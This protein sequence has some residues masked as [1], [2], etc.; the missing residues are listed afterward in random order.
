MECARVEGAEEEGSMRR[1]LYILAAAAQL[2]LASST[3]GQV[4]EREVRRNI[5]TNTTTQSGYHQLRAENGSSAPKERHGLKG[6][7]PGFAPQSVEEQSDFRSPST[8]HEEAI[9]DAG[10]LGLESV[11]PARQQPWE[12]ADPVK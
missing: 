10:S 9:V 5:T 7:S 1:K 4:I 6:S 8:R 11:L 3:Y 2:A 12:E